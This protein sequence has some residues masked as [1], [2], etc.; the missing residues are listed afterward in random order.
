MPAVLLMSS[1]TKNFEGLNTNPAGI[2]NDAFKADF[3]QII[4]PLQNAQKAIQHYGNYQIQQN[5]NAD[6]YS[7]YMMTPTPFNGGNNNSNYFMMDGWNSSILDAAYN[8]VQQSLADYKRLSSAYTGVDMSFPDAMAKAVKVLAMHRV[9]DIFGPI[10]YTHYGQPNADLSVTYD[11]QQDAYKA[12]FLDLDSAATGLKPF[13]SGDKKV[14]SAFGKADLIYAGNA[15]N[16]LKLVNTLRLRLA[17]RL[18]YADAATAKLQGEK[19]LDPASGGLI[20]D[21]AAN[22]LVDFGMRHPLSEIIGWDD[23]RSGAPLGAILGGYHDPRITHFMSPAT[24]VAVSGQ[25]IGIRNGVAIDDKARYSGYSKP[26]AKAAAADY[27]DAKDGKAKLASAAEVAFLKAEAALY[28]WANAGDAQEN[29]EN[30]ISTSFAEWAA[31]SAL[32]YINDATSTEDTYTDPKAKVAGAN[33]VATGSAFLSTITIKWDDAASAEAKLER[34][35]T[36]KWIAVYPDGQEAWTEFR[37]TGYPKLFGVVVN[38]S[39]GTIPGFIKRLPIPSKYQANNQPGYNAALT[40]L[41]GPDNGGTR[42]WWDNK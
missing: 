12:F 4:Q 3:Q 9:A 41:S 7:G 31:G 37:R 5:L 25:L 32:D 14:I 13:V 26:M 28:G 36:Q 35:M 15:T 29:Y 19:A 20:T 38:N 10:I 8:D 22:A 6:I 1:C 30:G 2:G 16:W 33:D 17:I 27:F 18:V 42:L 24:D 40:M 23:I 21:N 39:N 11:S 34:I